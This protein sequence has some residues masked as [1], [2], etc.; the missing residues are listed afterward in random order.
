MALFFLRLVASAF[1]GLAASAIY[2]EYR[3]ANDTLS[4]WR[5]RLD[6]T[7][8]LTIFIGLLGLIWTA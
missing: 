6:M 5:V 4:F 1:L 7:F 2:W 3:R 8:M